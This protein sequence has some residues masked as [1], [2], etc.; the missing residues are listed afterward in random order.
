MFEKVNLDSN[1]V[2]IILGVCSILLWFSPMFS[3]TQT[4]MGETTQMY[5]TGQHIGGIAY[6]ILVTAAAFAFLSWKKLWQL[7]I[8]AS[9]VEL[10]VCLLLAV[11]A[12]SSTAWGLIC[13][14]AVSG[15]GIFLSIKNFRLQKSAPGIDSGNNNEI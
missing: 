1:L 2:A 9:T 14:I 12:M 4:F 8:I 5:Q 3:W 7:A 15:T 11:Q 13:L 10:V 6:L